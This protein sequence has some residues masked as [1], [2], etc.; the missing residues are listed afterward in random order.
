MIW[1][2]ITYA[3]AIGLGWFARGLFD[4]IIQRADDAHNSGE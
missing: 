4:Y 3:C 1:S 2:A